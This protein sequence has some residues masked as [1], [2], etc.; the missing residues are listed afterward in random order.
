[1]TAFH[2]SLAAAEAV[3]IHTKTCEALAATRSPIQVPRH[4]G[5]LGPFSAPRGHFFV[6]E[7]TLRL[8][9]FFVWTTEYGHGETRAGLESAK[10]DSKVV[11]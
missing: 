1:M 6:D 2:R 7:K 10:N 5:V 9:H 11:A 8:C 4:V 3:T